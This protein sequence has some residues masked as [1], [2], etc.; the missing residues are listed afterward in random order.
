MIGSAVKKHTHR[1]TDG[2]FDPPCCLGQ[3]T[4]YIHILY[5]Y[6]KIYVQ[7]EAHEAWHLGGV[8]WVSNE[9]S[10]ISCHY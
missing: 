2:K 3:Y 5:I 8:D 9:I 10:S 7:P 1:A 4:Q 6:L